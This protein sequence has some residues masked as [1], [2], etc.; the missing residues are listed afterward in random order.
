MARANVPILF[1]LLLSAAAIP[2][3][4]QTGATGTIRGHVKLT[5]K[6]PGTVEQTSQLILFLASDASGHITGT[7][8]WIDGGQ[9]LVQG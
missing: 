3:T 2:A 7:E 9:S 8:L 5:G 1:A 6:I 4:A